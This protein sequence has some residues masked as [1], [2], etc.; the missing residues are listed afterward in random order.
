MPRI[1]GQ[2]LEVAKRARR[3]RN[4]WID[5]QAARHT[6]PCCPGCAHC[7]YQPV[8]VLIFEG[9]LIAFDREGE[10]PQGGRT[11]GEACPLLAAAECSIYHVRPI[12]CST[13]FPAAADCD[14]TTKN[15]DNQA[16]V[17]AVRELDIAF[18]RRIGF[19]WPGPLYLDAAVRVGWALLHAGPAAARRAFGPADECM[20]A[21][22]A[23]RLR[24]AA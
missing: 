8:G 6:F 23:K 5:E 24:G 10:L 15:L 17:H 20:P 3:L 14:E 4:R 12:S 2:A 9:A 11:R 7:C 1:F 18:C 19:A 21:G 13:L 16:P 22:R